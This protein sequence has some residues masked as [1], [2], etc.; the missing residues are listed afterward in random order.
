MGRAGP[1]SL[2]KNTIARTKTTARDDDPLPNLLLRAGRRG[3]EQ[4]AQLHFSGRT[5]PPSNDSMT[6]SGSGSKNESG[7]V[8]CPRANPI[9]RGWRRAR[10]RARISATGSLRRQCSIVS[11]S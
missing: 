2:D 8:N 9:G 10:G 7:T 11:P 6:S 1:R 5:V 3:H 4:P